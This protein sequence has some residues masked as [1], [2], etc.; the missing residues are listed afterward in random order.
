VIA[1]LA[2]ALTLGAIEHR[3]VLETDVPTTMRDGVVLR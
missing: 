2:L 1:A 3:V